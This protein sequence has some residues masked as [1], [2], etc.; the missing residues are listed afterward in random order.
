[1]E[2]AFEPWHWFVLGVLLMLSELILPALAYFPTDA[3]AELNQ[4]S[5][6]LLARQS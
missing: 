4:I 2:F 1:M 3:A 5:Q 6:F